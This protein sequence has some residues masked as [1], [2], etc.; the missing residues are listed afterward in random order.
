MADNAPNPTPEA[1]AWSP[2]AFLSDA[3]RHGA[4]LS[5]SGDG[6]TYQKAGDAR[7][8]EWIEIQLAAPGRI[9]AVHAIVSERERLEAEAA[10]EKARQDRENDWAAHVGYG[11]VGG[12]GLRWQEELQK[13]KAELERRIAAPSPKGKEK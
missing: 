5:T 3:E 11:S 9:D 8:P 13:I 6:L 10:A 7:V 1:P 12:G 2:E 4:R